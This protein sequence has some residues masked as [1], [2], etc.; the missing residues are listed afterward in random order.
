MIDICAYK[1]AGFNIKNSNLEMK[2]YDYA[3][4]HSTETKPNRT[5]LCNIREYIKLHQSDPSCVVLHARDH[6]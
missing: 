6:G 5:L 4:L 3:C 1:S 2:L